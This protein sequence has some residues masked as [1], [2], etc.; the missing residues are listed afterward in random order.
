MVC[1]TSYNE[2]T[3]TL[4]INCLG[5]IYGA[6]IEDSEVC[7]AR[8]IEKLFEYKKVS[9]IVLAE[10]RE[11]VY[12]SSQVKLLMEI[13]NSIQRIKRKGYASLENIVAKGCDRC[14]GN[15][16]SFVKNLI[17]GLK[18]DPINAY[19]QLKREI[20]HVK[21]KID[22]GDSC[23]QCLSFYLTH[24]LLPIKEILDT[25]EIFKLGVDV[26]EK[27]R[28]DRSF[29]RE[30]FNPIVRPNFMYTRYMATPPENAELVQRYRVK[31]SIVEI[32]SLPNNV[33]YLYHIILPEFR[34]GESDYI[35]LDTARRYLAEHKPRHSELS[36]PEKMRET[37]M[38]ISKDLILEIAGRNG[39]KL[40]ADKL[41][42]LAKILTRYTAGL[43]IIEV[44]LQDDKIQDISINSPIG[45][46]PV[47]IFHS[48]FEDCETNLIPTREDA[49]SWATRLRLLSGR[50]L[51][52]A[53]PVLDTEITV[54]GGRARVCAITRTLSPTGLA[55]ALRRHRERPWTYPLFISNRMMNPLAAGLLWFLI[56]NARTMLIAG[57]RSSGKTSLLGASLLQLMRK[58]RI[59]TVEDTLELPVERLRKLGYNI[60]Q[61]KSRSVITR[62]ETELPADEA[63]RTA[64]RLGDSC[65]IVGEVRSVEAKALYEAMRIGALANLVAGT[66]HGDSPYGVFDRV[67]ND[68]GVPTTSFKATDIIV[69]ANRLRSPDGLTTF[70]RLI[71]VTEVR[72]H[73]KSDPSEEGGF[74]DLLQYNAKYDEVVPTQTLLIG[75]SF[76]LGQI[77]SR[78]REW[79]GRW[80]ELWNNIQLRAKVMKTLAEFGGKKPNV[81][82]DEFVVKSNERFHII[83]K[84]VLEEFGSLDSEEIFKRWFEWF[85][86]EVKNA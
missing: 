83:S 1:E 31:D 70:R 64:L 13:A 48:D 28:S 30:I 46:T 75:E 81:M 82:E 12:N 21:V 15:K 36:D 27:P 52:E 25:C 16:Y 43:G 72:K 3:Q 8:I 58:S 29:Y 77:A 76:I 45:L 49:E 20:R 68:L 23:S 37:F 55:F 66:I 65:L 56:D 34:L 78:V 35:I 53:N 74:V 84:K 59:I 73:W 54:P 18:Y 17:D 33:R 41:D 24:S 19:R 57:T 79:R 6:S 63:L 85:K 10:S 9:E 51:D 4:R 44:L 67:V 32:Y 7:M 69:I 5:C 11:Y 26:I 86:E 38:N 80:D 62:V 40:S 60:E 50:P 22:R 42:L 61:L 71:Q 14:T 47:Y 39:V 2:E